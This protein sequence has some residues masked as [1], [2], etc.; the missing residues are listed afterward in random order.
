M[1]GSLA[2]FRE[3]VLLSSSFQRTGSKT[4]GLFFYVIADVI[5]ALKSGTYNCILLLR[6]FSVSVHIIV[7]IMDL[8]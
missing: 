8:V 5:T 3:S 7:W 2:H 6:V 1:M 4:V